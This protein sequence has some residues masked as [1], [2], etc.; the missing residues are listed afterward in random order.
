MAEI[1]LEFIIMLFA[2]V[3]II[4]ILALACQTAG[5]NWLKFF[6]GTHGFALVIGYIFFLKIL[7][8]FF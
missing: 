3:F 7:N 4:F 1:C 8:L 5:P 2:H 6:K